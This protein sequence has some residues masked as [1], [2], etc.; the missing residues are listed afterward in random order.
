MSQYYYLDVTLVLE[1][2]EV[3]VPRAFFKKN[4]VE[5][6]RK[7]FGEVGASVNID[8]L[9]YNSLTLRGIIRVPKSHYIKVRSSLT[10]CGRYEGQRCVY[11]V[12]KATPLLLA[13]QGDSRHYE[14]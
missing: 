14:H 11:I 12:H 8:I 3:G 1:I 10:L 4:I 9:K 2:P 7:V 13:L 5:A 6:V